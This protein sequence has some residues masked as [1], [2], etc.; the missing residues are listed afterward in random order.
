MLHVSVPAARLQVK[1]GPLVCACDT[2]VV[3][4]GNV[5]V[6]ETLAASDG[7]L[8]V[9]VTVYVTFDP[10]VPLAVEVFVIARLALVATIVFAVDELFRPTGSVVV[11]ATDA[12]FEIVPLGAEE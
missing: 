4:A 6:T 9:T 5:S 11:V 2:K 12:V 3:F 10:A 7:P 1:I 8:L